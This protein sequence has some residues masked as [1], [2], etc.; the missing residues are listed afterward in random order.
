MTTTR[1]Y[2][3]SRFER[4]WHWLQ[5]AIICGLVVTGLE[6]HGMATLLGFEQAVA[7]HDFLGMA[8][9]VTFL[10]FAFWLLTTGEWKQY[11]PTTRRM[12]A[13][14]RHYAFGILKGEPHP[15]TPRP[16]R[17][18]NPLQRLT[19][20][21]LATVLLPFQM[22]TGLAYHTYD[23]WNGWQTRLLAAPSLEVL[24]VLHVLGALAIAMFLVVHVYM[25]TT[26]H[27][28]T[29][30]LEAMCTGWERVGPCVNDE[31]ES[32]RPTPADRK[33]RV[34]KMP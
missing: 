7:A 14:M 16:E 19:Y 4:L 9:L 12:F 10:F 23:L 20:L 17:K 6:I 8:W 18:H 21:A 3:Y 15:F 32:E 22:I 11:I 30:H 1:I 28:V 2:I 25:T 27:R 26:G 24:A 5:A 31:Q 29:S 13:V 33:G 34:V